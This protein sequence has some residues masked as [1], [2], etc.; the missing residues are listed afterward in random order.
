MF[1][2]ARAFHRDERLLAR[3]RSG[4]ELGG[5]AAIWAAPLAGQQTAP[6]SRGTRGAASTQCKGTP[7]RE[8]HGNTA[9]RD[10]RAAVTDGAGFGAA[11]GRAES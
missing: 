8:L 11:L 9:Q 2:P 5:E 6:A 10:E 1:I 7:L 3:V 4:G